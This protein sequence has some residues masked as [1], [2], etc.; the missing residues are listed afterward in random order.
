MEEEEIV[1]SLMSYHNMKTLVLVTRG[2]VETDYILDID[3]ACTE[4]GCRLGNWNQRSCSST[5]SRP[6]LPT[7]SWSKDELI[8][9]LCLT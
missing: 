3:M 8:C 1:S 5:R 7:P 2:W 6:L 4:S 9:E